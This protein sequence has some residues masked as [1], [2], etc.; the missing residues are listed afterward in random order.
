MKKLLLS[1]SL[2]FVAAHHIPAKSVCPV[3]LVGP[4]LSNP[5][6][7]KAALIGALSWYY[8]IWKQ[9]APIMID[10]DWSWW[11][12][13]TRLGEDGYCGQVLTGN[14]EIEHEVEYTMMD[15]DSGIVTTVIENE[16]MVP[17]YGILGVLDSVVISKLKGFYKMLK[18]VK[19]F[20]Q[21]VD[22]PYDA[23]ELPK[24]PKA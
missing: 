19:H 12:V 20:R 13:I 3:P 4:Y 6:L 23:F 5:E 9:R 24:A 22:N 17:A 18:Y 14:R 21:F 16:V 8:F 2:L 11:H 15:P 1:L 10:E 7:H